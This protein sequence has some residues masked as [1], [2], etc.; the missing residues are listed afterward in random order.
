[1]RVNRLGYYSM[2]KL[3]LG[4]EKACNILRI[5]QLPLCI[6]DSEKREE[7]M[8]SGCSAELWKPSNYLLNLVQCSPRTAVGCP[9]PLLLLSAAHSSRWDFKCLLGTSKQEGSAETLGLR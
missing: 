5:Q 9:S 2:K 7:S 8:S 3:S 1:M 6:K 4:W